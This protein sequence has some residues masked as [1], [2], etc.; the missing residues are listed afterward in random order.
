M[1]HCYCYDQSKAESKHLHH[2][3][4]IVKHF[5]EELKCSLCSKGMSGDIVNVVHFSYDIH[6]SGFGFSTMT[7]Y[8]R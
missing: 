6:E 3:L 7:A 2:V 5:M 1:L 4:Q 8:K